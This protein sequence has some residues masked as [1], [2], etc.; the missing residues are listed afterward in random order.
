MRA[1]EQRAELINRPRKPEIRVVSESGRLG[2]GVRRAVVGRP[3]PLTA[4]QPID[5]VA[6]PF[7][8]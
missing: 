4:L 5:Y 8:P 3:Q 1:Q 7:H 2:A 6:R